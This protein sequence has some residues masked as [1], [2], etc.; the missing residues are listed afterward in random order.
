LKEQW[1]K[2]EGEN[3]RGIG[4]GRYNSEYLMEIAQAR[5]GFDWAIRLCD[6]YEHNGFD[7]WFLPSRDELNFMWGNL[8]M[9]GLGNFR[10]EQYWSSST[11]TDTWGSYRAWYI[12]FD[13]GKHDNQNANQQRRSRPIRQF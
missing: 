3:G 1:D 13:D 10:P 5:G 12:N 11:W 2:T 4:K 9:K 8:Y 6:N 7:D